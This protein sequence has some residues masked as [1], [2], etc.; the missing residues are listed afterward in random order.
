M[1]TGRLDPNIVSLVGD[2]LNYCGFACCSSSPLTNKELIKRS[3][4]IINGESLSLCGFGKGC[5]NN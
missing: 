4:K 3:G 2:F 5:S 1:L